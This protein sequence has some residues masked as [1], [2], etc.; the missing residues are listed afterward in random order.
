MV[1]N[2]VL[3]GKT[4]CEFRVAKL[5]NST[6]KMLPNIVQRL[7][8]MK[9][10]KVIVPAIS[11]LLATVF[12][13]GL[14]HSLPAFPSA[15][16]FGANTIGGRGGQVIKVTNLND[17][18]PGSFRE[19][20]TASGPRIVVFDVSGHINLQTDVTITTPYL[21]IAGQTS[22]GGVMVTGS[23]TVINT[24][25][26]IIQFMRFR[27][28]SHNMPDA[29]KHDNLAVLGRR[30]RSNDAYN[31]IFD[32]CSFSWAVDENMDLAGGVENFTLQWSIISEGLNDA[33]HPKGQHSKGLLVDGEQ[34]P[35]SI[36]IHHN[37]FAHNADR[38]PL[39]GSSSDTET[40]ADV[41]NNVMYNWYGGL[42]PLAERHAQVNWIHNYSKPG[43]SSNAS[44]RETIYNGYGG[45]PQQL[46]YVHGNIGATRLEQDNNH[47]TVGNSW[48]DEDLSTE[49]RKDTPWAADQ[50]N[51]TVMSHDYA[52]QV[53]QDVGANKP[54]RDSVDARVIADFGAGT[55]DIIDNV[56]Y[57]A[58][59][60]TFPNVTPPADSDNDGMADSWEI[61][62]GLDTSV[63]DAL[64]DND[65]DGYPNIEDYL[66]Y[67]ADYPPVG[68]GC[69]DAAP[70]M[71]P[72]N[73]TVSP[74]P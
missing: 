26:V 21:T 41:V 14:A 31:I 57:P 28:G 66:H 43:V 59:Y 24:N 4:D 10:I 1:Q 62:N 61:A 35:S 56:S 25:D 39:V 20:V 22:P 72:S 64:L 29:E 12:P 15:E 13:S 60:P 27:I 6:Q 5:K 46:L 71:P 17:S 68:S 44:S 16:G 58:D 42:A 33:G 2:S 45:A 34:Y 69:G 67:L 9:V 50:V 3:F 23:K 8:S 19:A 49:Y 7:E 65:C 11:L 40:R 48:R 51:T 55:G 73:L 18:G 47:W 53:V 52:L 36:S 37:Y 74:L 32:H 38:N 63:N 70:P 30:W 54:A